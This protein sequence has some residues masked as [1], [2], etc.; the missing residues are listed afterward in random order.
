M[1][2]KYSQ[3]PTPK[4]RSYNKIVW[5]TPVKTSLGALP[6]TMSL[7]KPAPPSSMKNGTPKTTSII[8]PSIIIATK[9]SQNPAY[10]T[11]PVRTY[12]A[13][14][15]MCEFG[16]GPDPEISVGWPGRSQ[17]QPRRVGHRRDSSGLRRQSEY[18]NENNTSTSPMNHFS[19]DPCAHPTGRN[20]RSQ[21]QAG[22]GQR[23]ISEGN[24]IA[25]RSK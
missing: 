13:R 9:R 3:E 7:K 14:V 2:E 23:D 10:P 24:T 25:P 11:E 18:H 20:P 21:L 22:N 19:D 5:E 4:I 12:G 6:D 17:E 8:I 15:V 1:R 16:A